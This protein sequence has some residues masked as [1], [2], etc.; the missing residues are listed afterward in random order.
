[1]YNTTLWSAGVVYSGEQIQQV[2]IAATL[3][4]LLA[5]PIPINSLGVL[6]DNALTGLNTDQKLK[7]AYINA[8]QILRVAET[9]LAN[10]AHS[11]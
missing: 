10:Y 8:V 2:D 3:A 1:M 7:A 11:K 6:I 5:V 9:G 4:V